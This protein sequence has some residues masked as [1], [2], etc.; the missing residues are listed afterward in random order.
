MHL[1]ET[2]SFSL[3]HD[4][5][6]KLTLMGDLTFTRWSRYEALSVDFDNSLPT[7]TEDKDW[8][9]VWRASV[10]VNYRLNNQWLLRAGYAHDA[11][12]VPN[13]TR[14][15]RVPDG[16]RNW[17]TIGTNFKPADN[18]SIDLA[19]AYLQMND[20]KSD[21]T[22]SLGHTLVGDYENKTSYFSI[23]GNFQ[24]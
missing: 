23:Q 10:G 2:L 7:S 24:F 3:A 13:E 19:Y 22:D 11:S 12:P 14:D 6:S 5:S 21:L 8:N 1:P 18:Y 15:P 9:D 4:A 16:D 20:V 17:F